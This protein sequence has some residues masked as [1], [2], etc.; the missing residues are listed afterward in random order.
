MSDLFNPSTNDQLVDHKKY[1]GN[2][3]RIFGE[4]KKGVAGKYI[5]KEGKIVPVGEEPT[6]TETRV[7]RRYMYVQKP[8]EYE[9]SCD[10]CHGSNIQW[11]EWEGLI[12]CY[13]CKVDTKG[14]G[15]VFDGPIP[16]QTAELLGLCFDRVDIENGK[17]LKFDT[18]EWKNSFKKV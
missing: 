8:Q 6:V 17:I 10:R 16:I 18:E 1:D 11:S 12:W 9:M 14:D 3:D 5:Y 13:D 7:K 15:G 2:F 4:R